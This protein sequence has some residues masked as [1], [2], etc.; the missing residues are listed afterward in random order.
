MR[1]VWKNRCWRFIVLTIY[2][3]TDFEFILP[4]N[5]SI[6]DE[7][8]GVLTQ[9]YNNSTRLEHLLLLG[10]H[11]SN[12]A[13]SPLIK[14]IVPD[15]SHTKHTYVVRVDALPEKVINSL[16]SPE[17]ISDN[18]KNIKKPNNSR[19]KI[20]IPWN[21]LYDKDSFG[22]IRKR[23]QNKLLFALTSRSGARGNDLSFDDSDQ[24]KPNNHSSS[25]ISHIGTDNDSGW[26]KAFTG[27]Q[28]HALGLKASHKTPYSSYEKRR[29]LSQINVIKEASYR[30][31]IDKEI[32]GLKLKTDNV[33]LRR[34]KRD[35]KHPLQNIT[36]DETGLSENGSGVHPGRLPTGY[37]LYYEILKYMNQY[38]NMSTDIGNFTTN[39]APWV[40]EVHCP[41]VIKNL[42][43][44]VKALGKS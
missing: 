35:E 37:D 15:G 8:T 2:L 16:A 32:P 6:S 22:R 38:L 42:Y 41:D 31:S 4:T 30:N 40:I 17:Y 21:G 39:T 20:L 1:F 3:N 11:S 5:G 33:T 7:A 44:T 23:I 12:K 24:G 25:D 18:T 19:L 10:T 28:F 29:N 34:Y 14:S 13:R 9:T 27:E 26:D 43:R 36:I